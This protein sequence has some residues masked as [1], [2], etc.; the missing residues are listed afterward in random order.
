MLK[1]DILVL[2]VHPDDA[3]LGCAGTILKHLALGQKVGIVDLTRGELGT[4]GSAGI[5]AQEAAAAAEILGLT[6]RENLGLPDGFFKND[7][8][9]QRKVIT[10]I[11]K[12]QPD[13]VITNAYH[14]RHPDHGR[15]NELV[16]ASAFLSGLRK[17]ET[18]LDGNP[19]K[20]WRP[21]LVLH[22]IQDNYIKPD[23]IVDVTEYW[24]KK[25]ES[26]KAYGSQFFNPEWK[27]EHQT[28]ISSEGFYQVIEGRAREFGKSIQ[29]KYGE[30]F[31]SRKIL[32][33]DNLS[34]LK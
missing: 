34:A 7:E 4:R 28:Y 3:E 21:K 23:I 8:E 10:A 32:G 16:E 25:I 27:E 14:D 17:I 24:D 12:Y 15:A 33:V 5:R 29:V 9:H 18:E 30:G 19:Q 6:V 20:E 13:I 1:L 2:A 31:T 11:R 22:F 26:V